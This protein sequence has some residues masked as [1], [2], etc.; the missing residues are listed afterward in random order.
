MLEQLIA[1]LEKLP[2]EDLEL[3]EKIV[4][5][6]SEPDSERTIRRALLAAAAGSTIEI[7]TAATMTQR[8]AAP[9]ATIAAG[10]AQ[11]VT[12]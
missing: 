3:I 5:A 12:T 11:G 7:A 8:R 6:L 1:I 9:G 4:N 2:P 10:I